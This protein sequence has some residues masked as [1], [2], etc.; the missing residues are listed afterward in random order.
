MMIRTFVC[1]TIFRCTFLCP[2]PNC[3]FAKTRACWSISHH[4][5]LFYTILQAVMPT[6]DDVTFML[7]IMSLLIN[8][9]YGYNPDKLCIIFTFTS[10]PMFFKNTT[11]THPMYKIM[12]KY[13]LLL[14]QCVCIYMLYITYGGGPIGLSPGPKWCSQPTS[15]SNQA[16]QTPPVCATPANR[17]C[18][19]LRTCVSPTLPPHASPHT[20]SPAHSCAF[21][22]KCV[23]RSWTVSV[24]HTRNGSLIG[25][26]YM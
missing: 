23:P 15:W 6:Y 25:H 13:C 7:W 19:I 9:A 20:P 24:M 22:P 14:I 8:A 4:V 5:C 2:F 10:L 21:P 12:L 17:S 16:N 1:N 26:A 18:T 11:P 3:F